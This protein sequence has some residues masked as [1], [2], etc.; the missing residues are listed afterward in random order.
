[1]PEIDFVCVKSAVSASKCTGIGFSLVWILFFWEPHTK[2]MLLGASGGVYFG[3]KRAD[4]S[5]GGASYR[6]LR[7]PQCVK[8]GCKNGTRMRL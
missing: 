4:Q 7:E 3:V 2:M 5:E 1:M 6:H 8:K